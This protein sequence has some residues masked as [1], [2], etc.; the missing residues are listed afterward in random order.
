M[1]DGLDNAELQEEF[2]SEEDPL[3]SALLAVSSFTSVCACWLGVMEMTLRHPGY[4]TRVG[5]AALIALI[6]LATILVRKTDLR[7]RGEWWLWVGAVALIGIGGQ[8]FVRNARAAHFEGFVL[9]ISVALVVQGLLTL[10]S[11]MGRKGPSSP[12]RS[13]MQR[14]AGE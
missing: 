1:R 6:S 12:S 2:S 5:V 13:T 7:T 11:G 3:R 4:G 8:A 14:L 10:V 9:V